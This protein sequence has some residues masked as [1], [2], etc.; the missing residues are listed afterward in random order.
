MLLGEEGVNL[1]RQ[2]HVAL[3]GLGGVGGMCAE[4]LCRCGIG[5]LTVVDH[6]VFDV[7]NLNRQLFATEET[8]GRKKTEV[9]RER[10]HSIDPGCRVIPRD[11]FYLPETADLFDLS[12]YD[13]VIDAIDTVT[14]KIDLISRCTELHV[15]VISAMGAG[16][17]LDPTALRAADISETSVDPLAKVMRRELR[18]R[19]I[20]HCRVVYSTEKPVRAGSTGN[21]E[22]RA[23]MPAGVPEYAENGD[24]EGCAAGKAA[25]KGR[26]DT[27]GSA[28]FVPPAMGLAIAS[29]VVRDLLG[30]GRQPLRGQ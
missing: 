7:T 2:K 8:V 28:A 5:A 15:P 19:G 30:Q 17:K 1:L 4:A 13:Y 9:C 22:D 3:F 27:P 20:E 23:G 21:D 29:E 25:G 6:D 16:N 10:L 14:A 24:A 18:K 11:M 26:K 12:Q